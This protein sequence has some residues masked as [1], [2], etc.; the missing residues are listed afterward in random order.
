MKI[1]HLCTHKSSCYKFHSHE[2]SCHF[3]PSNLLPPLAS[4]IPPAPPSVLRAAGDGAGGATSF[5][6]VFKSSI[7][8]ICVLCQGKP[9]SHILSLRES[10]IP[11]PYS[12]VEGMGLSLNPSSPWEASKMIRLTHTKVKHH[13]LREIHHFSSPWTSLV[14]YV[15]FM[16][17]FHIYLTSSQFFAYLC[18]AEPFAWNAQPA[19]I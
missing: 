1:N 15:S 10:R 7:Q 13:F 9:S 17:H 19:L 5:C 3:S 12:T 2:Y 11:I 14:L 16:T 8:D 18:I 6:L 4:L